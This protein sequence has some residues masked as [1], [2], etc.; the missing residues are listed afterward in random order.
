MSIKELESAVSHLYPNI[1]IDEVRTRSGVVHRAYGH[2]GRVLVMWDTVG[3][4]YT[5]PT[6]RLLEPEEREFFYKLEAEEC[7]FRSGLYDLGI[8]FKH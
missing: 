4:S 6:I 8:Y 5:Y 2:V 7:F 1:H 3:R